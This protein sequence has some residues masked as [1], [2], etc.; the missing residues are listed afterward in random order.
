VIEPFVWNLTSSR[1]QYRS[2]EQYS[3]YDIRDADW[4]RH[5]PN[6][7]FLGRL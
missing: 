3:R 5:W 4:S 2:I 6:H 1:S 7:V